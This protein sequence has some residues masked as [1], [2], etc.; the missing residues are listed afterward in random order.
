MKNTLK[1]IAICGL[2][3]SPQLF[4][5]DTPVVPSRMNKIGTAVKGAVWNKT[6]GKVSAV[7]ATSAAAGIATYLLTKNNKYTAMA[8][9]AIPAAL[10]LA[11]LVYK[12][13]PYVASASVTAFNGTISAAKAIAKTAKN[14]WIRRS[15]KSKRS[16]AAKSAKA[17]ADSALTSVAALMAE[18]EAA[19]LM[20]NPIGFAQAPDPI[21]LAQAPK[22]VLP[23]T[24]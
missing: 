22:V 24:V 20:A 6:T 23:A 7:V 19:A 17:V 10:G 16:R 2:L 21:G 15:R 3:A 9:A 1:T 13:T 11:Y 18:A 12:S 8:V 5:M 4:C 14:S